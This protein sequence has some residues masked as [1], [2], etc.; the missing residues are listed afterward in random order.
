LDL[1][2]ISSKGQAQIIESDDI[3]F[4]DVPILSPN[5]DVMIPKMNFE[6]AAG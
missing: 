6:I 1:K 5:G 3:I 4:K 2:T